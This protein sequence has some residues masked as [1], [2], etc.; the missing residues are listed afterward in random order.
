MAMRAQ[1]SAFRALRCILGIGLLLGTGGRAVFAEQ[2]STSS[3]I[4]R[5][6]R[7]DPKA[8][9]AKGEAAL[10][11]GDLKEAEAAFRQVLAV[12]PQAGGAYTNLGVIAMRRKEWD[13]ALGLLEKAAK[14]DPKVSGIRLNIGLVNY[15]RG[16]YAAAI[17]PLASVVRDQP[18]SQQ[19]R[20][21][22]GL[23]NFFTGHYDAAVKA[24]EPLWPVMSS[25]VMYLYV[26]S[27]AAHSAGQ[28]DLD[29]R[30]LTR[31]MELGVNTPEFHLIL[32]KA[33]LNHK[34]F[35][36]ALSELN[37]ASTNP[38]LPFLHFN[39]GIAYMRT[40]QNERAVE[41]F[42]KDIAIEPDVAENYEQLGMLYARVDRVADAEKAF[43]DAIERDA[44]LAGSQFGLAK[45][46]MKQERNAEALRFIDV[47][48]ELA[49]DNQN[50]H[51]VRGQLL[52]RLGRSEEAKAEIAKA[53][54][55]FD[56]TL[57]S[58]RDAVEEGRMPNPE[59]TREPQP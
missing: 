18:D 24:L 59:L 53:Q 23:C 39:F 26:F 31:L 58:D 40:N 28:N 52:K 32:A 25:D 33:Y 42:L 51:F 38:K 8:L 57:A 37:N 4:T 47:A 45:L 49:P 50:V 2:Q 46:Y 13:Q 7:P 27:N 16:D 17:E 30:A 36:R 11:N 19:A 6:K 43:R 3:Q 15:R 9:F 54:K 20:Y 22:L 5:K 1:F 12:D 34:D 35:D 41:E 10:K 56:S 14:L 48:V 44:R 21:L 29:E 55:I